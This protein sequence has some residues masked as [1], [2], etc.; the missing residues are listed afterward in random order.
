MVNFIQSLAK[1]FVWQ[2]NGSVPSVK[3]LDAR[4]G[5]IARQDVA[6]LVGEPAQSLFVVE[7]AGGKVI[8][9]LRLA[10]TR[11]DVVVGEM[12]TIF[13]SDPANHYALQRRR[14]RL[15]RHRRGTALLLGAANSDNYYHWSLESLPRWRMA[16]LAGHQ[17]Y[18]FVLLH[19]QPR[20]F[21]DEMLDRLGVP[22]AKRLRCS[23]NFAH[24]FDRLILPAMPS[25]PWQAKAWVCDWLRSL[26]PPGRSGPEKIYLSRSG[27]QRRRL[28]NEAELAIRLKDL[29]FVTIQPERI[30]V[31]EQAALFSAARC[32]VAPHGAGLTNMVFAPPGA[33]LLELFH[34]QH[35]NTCYQNLA[36]ACRQHYASMDGQEIH[37]A[38]SKLLEYRI[39]VDAVLRAL[40]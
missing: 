14:L 32:V 16:Q 8:G 11:D 6:P 10:A 2:A 15:A 26:F 33:R 30:S 23:K 38:G 12:Q 9:D 18:D 20:A 28:L 19:S 3:D 34:P 7:L 5:V 40:A 21:Q 25:P 39:D 4:H 29:G 24:R 17:E 27:Q 37:S 22:E 35:R 1:S 13:G 31:A 36:A